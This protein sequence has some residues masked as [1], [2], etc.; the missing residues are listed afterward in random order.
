[1]PRSQSQR[2]SRSG[3]AGGGKARRDRSRDSQRSLPSVAS[4]DTASRV[5]AQHR[6]HSDG[7]HSATGGGVTGGSQVNGYPSDAQQ[8][9][10]N[11]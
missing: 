4:A 2:L 7:A 8:Y 11:R 1:M 6:M 9:Y 5:N 3:G 10:V